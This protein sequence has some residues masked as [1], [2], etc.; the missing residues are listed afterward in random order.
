LREEGGGE[1]LLS[2]LLELSAGS[3]ETTR[4]PS[5]ECTVLVATLGEGGVVV[6]VVV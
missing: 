3:G 4:V 2:E 1:K 5:S 6:V